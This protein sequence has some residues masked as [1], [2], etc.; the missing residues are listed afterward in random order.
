MK[1]KSMKIK[2]NQTDITTI[3]N[4]LPKTTNTL[5]NS[6]NEEE[7]Y[8]NKKKPD[9]YYHHWQYIAQNHQYSEKFKK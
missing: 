1:K 9:R 3:D 5:K 7:K 4:T 8:E 2:R 6:K